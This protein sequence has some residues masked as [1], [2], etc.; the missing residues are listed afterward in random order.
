MAIDGNGLLKYRLPE[1]TRAILIK[2]Y[3]RFL[4]DVKL[5]TGRIITVH[6]PNSGSMKGC[7]VPGS[8]VWIS[9]S[10]NAK[11][12]YAYTWELIQLPH[13]LVGINTLLPNRLV[14]TA[15]ENHQIK[16]LSGYDMIR[17]EVKTSAH[18]RLDLVLEKKSGAA[19]YVEIKNCTLVEDGT[20]MFPDAVTTRGQKHLDELEFLVSQG[21]RGV[22]FFLVQRMD[23]KVFRPAAMIDEVYARKLKN[24]SEKGVEIMVFDTRIDTRS[25]QLAH[26]VPVD[27][28]SGL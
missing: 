15:I 14:K 19:C 11:R 3:K 26:A 9:K 27:L 28:D 10:L 1:L 17:S 13:T 7:A 5:E 24:V 22:L 4:A 2:R 8:L 6:C 21:H 12:K 16:A 23:A 18:T 25:I 20:A